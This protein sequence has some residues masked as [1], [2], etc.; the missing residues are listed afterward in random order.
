M[1]MQT[2]AKAFAVPSVMSLASLSPPAA[3]S[4]TSLQVICPFC[5]RIFGIAEFHKVENLHTMGNDDFV[6][7]QCAECRKEFWILEKDYDKLGVSE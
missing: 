6:Y 1:L 4:K 2:I 3:W 5:S 7:F